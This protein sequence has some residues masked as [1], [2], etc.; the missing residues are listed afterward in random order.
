[1]PIAFDYFGTRNSSPGRL[2]SNQYPY[3]KYTWVAT[4]EFDKKEDDGS[5]PIVAE[6]IT[7]KTFELPRWTAD[8][9]IVNVYNHKTLVQTKLSWEPITITFYDQQNDE[10]DRLIWNYV[11]G[12]FDPR[13]GSKAPRIKPLKIT[14]ELHKFSEGG[15]SV[16]ENK[17]Y[18]MEDVYII[19]AQ[20]DTLDYSTSDPVLWTISV[21]F[22]N[23][24]WIGGFEGDAGTSNAG[25]AAKP[26]EPLTPEPGPGSKPPAKIEQTP[27]S[28]DIPDASP[29]MLEM[30]DGNTGGNVNYGAVNHSPKG[31]ARVLD[32]QRSREK[33][34]KQVVPPG[35]DSEP[36]YTGYEGGFVPTPPG[37]G[38]K[39]FS[40][41]TGTAKSTTTTGADSGSRRVDT[42]SAA[43]ATGSR[44]ANPESIS[45]SKA[46]QI[47]KPN[48]WNNTNKAAQDERD[49]IKAAQTGQSVGQVRAAR[50]R[51][52]RALDKAVPDSSWN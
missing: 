2:V 34:S 9:Q 29:G 27:P 20:H 19:D 41:S 16:A 36:T 30:M 26:L 12:Q 44:N 11:K 50:E 25:I 18:I 28:P 38:A 42:P 24:T 3:Y 35:G 33:A 4:F 1:M 48:Y 31:L 21:R 45:S 15:I 37:E 14:V 13:D 17:T 6:N 32:E 51:N 49:R 10:V 47:S 8:T 23:L 43:T 46:E 52:A 7:L 40:P 39:G 22:E 5:S